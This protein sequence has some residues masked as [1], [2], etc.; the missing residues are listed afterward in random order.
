MTYPA[1][2]ANA[3]RP[4]QAGGTLPEEVTVRTVDGEELD[5]RQVVLGRPV[6]LVFYRG[7]WCPYCNTHLKELAGI[8]HQ[9]AELGVGLVALS[10]DTPGKLAEALE[11]EQ[12]LSYKLLSDSGHKAMTA[13]GV[14][15]TVDPATDK[16]LRDFGVDLADW[17]GRSERVLPVPSVFVVD[18][19]GT[20]R[21][22]HAEPDYTTRLSGEDLLQAA[23]D[24][25]TA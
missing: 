24:T 15:F 21:F 7:G 1:A 2:N 25:V 17:S 3:T 20:I 19:S 5:L 11:G 14:A 10:P 13:F 23:R 6:V 9:L 12:A 18:Q 16:Q 22:A 4:L 8:R